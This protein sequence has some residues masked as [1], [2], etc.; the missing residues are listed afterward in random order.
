MNGHND[1]NFNYSR[2]IERPDV[3]QLSP[4]VYNADYITERYTGNE[5]LQPAFSSSFDFGYSFNK[6]P[7]GINV[8]VFYMN[9][10]DE[11]D[12]MFL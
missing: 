9:T 3:Y 12:R 8:S 1:F 6:K 7:F 4:I 11:I 2:R 5:N 10:K